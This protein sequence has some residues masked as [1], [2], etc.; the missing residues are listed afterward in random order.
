MYN[1]KNIMEKK[2]IINFSDNARY[3]LGQNRLLESLKNTGYTGDVFVENNEK[4]IHFKS[5]KEINYGFKA[6]MINKVKNLGYRYV[7]WI[8]SSVYAG[9]DVSPIFDYIEKNGYFVLQYDE[10]V[11]TSGEWCC[12]TALVPLQITREESFEIPHAYATVFGLDLKKHSGFFD[13]YLR[14]AEEG[15]AFNG[16]WYNRENQCSFDPRVKG[17]RHDQ[18]VMSVLMWKMGMRNWITKNTVKDFTNFYNYKESKESIL[19]YG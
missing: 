17:H 10:G 8:D 19:I 4:N 3:I 11:S 2:C 18:T 13:E 6:G 15:T 16:D 9:K 5:H 14:L 12:D 7:L 1:R